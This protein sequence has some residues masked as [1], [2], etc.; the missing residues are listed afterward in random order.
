MRD[1]WRALRG[2]VSALVLLGMVALQALVAGVL[3]LGVGWVAVR[4]HFKLVELVHAQDASSVTAVAAGFATVAGAPARIA[5][6]P[7]AKVNDLVAV[8]AGERNFAC[9]G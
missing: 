8:V 7:F 1:I 3:G 5:N 9:A 4:E 6:R 2:P